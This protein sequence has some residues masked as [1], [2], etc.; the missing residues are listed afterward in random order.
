VVEAF[1]SEAKAISIVKRSFTVVMPRS[2]RSRAR[3]WSTV[4]GNLDPDEYI[5]IK[6]ECLRAP[7]EY[8]SIH[9]YSQG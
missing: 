7:V 8:C 6:Q 1:R 4:A 3:L 9:P 2:S 5:F